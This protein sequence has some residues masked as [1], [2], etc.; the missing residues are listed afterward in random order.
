MT[1]YNIIYTR[2]NIILNFFDGT[3]NKKYKNSEA[4]YLLDVN[5]RIIINFM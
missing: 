5:K 2:I 4:T 1:F 3:Y